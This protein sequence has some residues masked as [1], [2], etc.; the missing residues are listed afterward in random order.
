MYIYYRICEKEATIS[1]VKRYGDYSK[2]TILRKSFA[3]LAHQLTDEDS[4][5]I[6]HDEV[7]EETLKWV[8]KQIPAGLVNYVEVPKHPWDY[9]QHTV[10]LVEELEKNI[11]NNNDLHLLIEDDYLFAPNALEIVKSL[12]G[13]YGAFFVPYDYPDRYRERIPCLVLTGTMCHWRTIHSCTMTIGATASAWRE[14]LPLLKE[15]APTSND[16][17]F[18]EIFKKYSCISPLPG[19]ATHMTDHHHTPYFKVQERF[20]E[21]DIT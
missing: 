13:I 11:Q 4:I 21:L 14:V 12:Q 3:S 16:K 7:S 17:V 2:K 9:H 10:T 5:T 15:A 19:V 18:E 20:D 6:I 8:D 1:H